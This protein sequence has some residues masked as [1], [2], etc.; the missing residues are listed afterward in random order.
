MLK[1]K[2]QY[3]GH[4]MQRTDS[5]VKMPGK[6]E[7]RRKRGWQRMKWLDG[8]TNSMDLSLSK[9]WEL[10]MDR[11]VW[12]VVV[13]WVTKIWTWL[14][15]WTELNWRMTFGNE[16]ENS[17]W[18][19]LNIVNLKGNPVLLRKFLLWKWKWYNAERSSNNTEQIWGITR[20]DSVKWTLITSA[21]AGYV[22][23]AKPDKNSFHARL[24]FLT[25]LLGPLM[26][27][28]PENIFHYCRRGNILPLIS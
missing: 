19:L 1:L 13:H 11:E 21:V 5:L 4:M 17:T 7:G 10:M 24:V 20:E 25:R 16:S 18:A 8:I 26:I 12:C 22:G 3:F 28:I 27:L 23:T 14:R 6:T 9:F 15:D 2:L